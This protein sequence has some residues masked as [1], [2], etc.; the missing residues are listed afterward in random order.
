MAFLFFSYSFNNSIT[1]LSIGIL[2][3]FNGLF[4]L[5]KGMIKI[6]SNLID[7]TGLQKKVDQNDLNKIEIY[8]DRILLINVNNESTSLD[9]FNI[10]VN[11]A[12]LIENYILSN[13]TNLELSIINSAK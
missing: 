4:D 3:L 1:G 8:N 12:L 11:S 5:P 13:K 10:D 7:I 6:D 2:V 9:N